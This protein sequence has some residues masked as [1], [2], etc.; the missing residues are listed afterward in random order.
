MP[1]SM[2][3]PGSH[4]AAADQTTDPD[5]GLGADAEALILSLG[6]TVGDRLDGRYRL[7]RVL[8]TTGPAIT[9]LA[10]D[11]KLNR[12][13]RIHLLRSDQPRAEAF[14]AAARA[15]AAMADNHFVQV[16]DAVPDEGLYYV[17]TEWLHDGHTLGE[18]LSG[19]PV[20]VTEAVRITTELARAITEAHDQGL[21]H[22]RLSPKTVLRTD[23]GEVKIL[24]LCLAAALTGTVS[25]DPLGTDLS[26]IGELAYA[27]LT[28]RRPQ[29]PEPVPPSELR[30]EVTP[31][32]DDVILRI[33]GD[34]PAGPQFQTP[35]EVADALAQLPRPR[36]EAPLP[37]TPQT[38]PLRHQQTTVMPA[39]PAGA[40][41]TT[42]MPQV[43]PSYQPTSPRPTAHG[44]APARPSSYDEDEYRPRGGGSGAGHG[45]SRGSDHGG[46][47]GG[48]NSSALIGI[49]GLAAVVAIA[50]LAYTMFNGSSSKGNQNAGNTS[51]SNSQTSTTGSS[52]APASSDITA[53]SVSIYNSDPTS[54]EGQLLNNQIGD[55][56]W[57]TNQYCGD[58]ATF[59]GNPKGTGLIFDL[60]SVKT[61]SNATVTIGT[62]GAA[63]EMWTAN[64]SVTAVPA[65]AGGQPPTGFT[66]SAS[67]DPGS[68]TVALKAGSPV[69][70]RFVLIWFTKPLP[71]VPNPNPQITCAHGSSSRY[72]DS[73]MS[74]K[75]NAS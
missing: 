22:L 66:K 24:D 53:A 60:G 40:A 3:G 70:T 23:T 69:S 6:V 21:A 1:Q 17:I 52:Q 12:P 74:V 26:A 38:A 7:D 27:L 2:H 35:V 14:M 43:A 32:L 42:A 8:H 67:A 64:S 13:N 47:G 68:T 19:G 72:G 9:W 49:G 63:M 57:V 15:A 75:F 30:S 10:T 71:A 25:R 55:K 28:G 46:G 4:V 59:N 73:I 31:Q 48:R 61:I 45:G 51:T 29:Q 37:S 33:L 65:V 20:P 50:L 18:V 39:L 54:S 58:E 11:E 16:L 56:G 5:G 62:A 34:G 44:G 36:Y 41:R